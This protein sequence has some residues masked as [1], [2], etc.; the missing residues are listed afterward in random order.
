M[1]IV[2]NKELYENL[3]T[4]SRL[5][6]I[7]DTQELVTGSFYTFYDDILLEIRYDNKIYV[8]E[9]YSTQGE[10]KLTLDILK[11]DLDKDKIEDVFMYDDILII[12]SENGYY[13]CFM[14]KLKENLNDTSKDIRYQFNFYRFNKQIDYRPYSLLNDVICIKEDNHTL[15]FKS[16]RT[17][18]YSKSIVFDQ[19]IEGFSFIS[20]NRIAISFYNEPYL[21]RVYDFENNKYL[22][23]FRLNEN[24]NGYDYDIQ[25]QI[26][27]I[28]KYKNNLF[29][30]T[31]SG[32]IYKSKITDD[33][34]I[35]SLSYRFFNFGSSIDYIKYVDEYIIFMNR[36]NEIM[37]YNYEYDRKEFIKNNYLV[38]SLALSKFMMV[39]SLYDSVDEDYKKR[40]VESGVTPS[41]VKLNPVEKFIMYNPPNIKIIDERIEY[42]Y[43][44]ENDPLVY[45]NLNIKLEENKINNFDQDPYR[46]KFNVADNESNLYVSESDV[47][48]FDKPGSVKN[49]YI[50]LGKKSEFIDNKK[51]IKD[52]ENGNFKYKFTIDNL[53]NYVTFHDEFYPDV[54]KGLYRHLTDTEV[55]KERSPQK[56]YFDGFEDEMKIKDVF[57]NP[58]NEK[59]ISLLSNL[60]NEKVIYPNSKLNINSSD[61]YLDYPDYDSRKY[62]DLSNEYPTGQIEN[63]VVNSDV[64]FDGYKVFKNDLLQ[65]D[66]FDGSINLYLKH[67]A[68]KSY[69]SKAAYNYMIDN[70]QLTKAD[71]III[72][73]KSRSLYE[74]EKL[75]IKHKVSNT[76]ENQTTLLP[77]KGILL[78]NTRVKQFK[79]QNIRI[80][81]KIFKPNSEDNKYY[82]RLNP[83]NYNL[84]IDKEYEM[85]RVSIFGIQIPEGSE[86]M[87]M[88]NGLTN[89]VILYDKLNYI[90]RDIDSLPIVEIAPDGELL[91]ELE[92]R[93][94][95]TEVIVNGLTL[96]PNRDF[97]VINTP[98]DPEI[99]SMVAFRNI[100]PNNAKVEITL[101][102][103]NSSD[104]YYFKYPA[105]GTDNVFVL[106]DDKRIFTN[107][108]YQNDPYK[109]INLLKDSDEE[110][111]TN[112]DLNK[113]YDLLEPLE[114]G[115][116]YTLTMRGSMPIDIDS[117]D[118]YLN[119]ASDKLA[120]IKSSSFDLDTKTYQVTF[121]ADLS[122]SENTK[123]ILKK[124]FSS[125]SNIVI[126]WIKLKKEPSSTRL[127]ENY[128][129]GPE[130]NNKALN[131][132]V[133]VNNKKI[134][135]NYVTVLN[136]KAISISDSYFKLNNVMVRFNFTYDENL[137]RVID[138]YKY[139]NI[140]VNEDRYHD[141]N[142]KPSSSPFD[143]LTSN[144]QAKTAGNLMLLSMLVDTG[145][146]IIDCNANDLPIDINLNTSVIENT[147]IKRNINLD[148]NRT[149][150]IETINKVSDYIN[151]IIDV[152]KNNEN[153][154]LHSNNPNWFIENER[155]IL[156]EP[157]NIELQTNEG[158]SIE[159]LEN[160]EWKVISSNNELSLSYVPE[161]D[162]LVNE[163]DYT[164]SL[165]VNPN[166][167]SISII[168]LE[169]ENDKEI[170]LK[171]EKWT[172]IHLPFNYNGE[173]K[174]DILIKSKE[175]NSNIEL[176]Y[177]DLKLEKGLNEK[178][179]FS[180]APED[181]KPSQFSYSKP[182]EYTKNFSM[183]EHIRNIKFNT[184]KNINLKFELDKDL[185]EFD[186]SYTFSFYAR[187]KSEKETYFKNENLDVEFKLEKDEFRIYL[188]Y[189][190]LTEDSIKYFN[191]FY[192]VQED[193]EKEFEIDLFGFKLEKG[194]RHTDYLPNVKDIQS[195]D[196]ISNTFNIDEKKNSNLLQLEE[197]YKLSLD[198]INEE[199]IRTNLVDKFNL[200][201]DTF[202][203]LSMDI[204]IEKLNDL[205]TNTL[206][207]GLMDY[208]DK[209]LSSKNIFYIPLDNFKKKEKFRAF[210]IFFIS[211]INNFK[212]FVLR[213][214]YS[215]EQSSKNVMEFS[216][217]KLEKGRIATS[218]S[219]NSNLVQDSI[220]MDPE[221]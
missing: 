155:N 149:N 98:N 124:D 90:Q 150:L 126:D 164:F 8:Y 17:D 133:F 139:K 185:I 162:I 109:G 221:I 176:H 79:I 196:T 193:E 206:Y 22:Q 3:R 40:I 203:T 125:S 100:I 35:D 11:E 128:A 175:E 114:K 86:I 76:Y 19:N 153:L 158:N 32:S 215:A 24:L 80:Y 58:D 75:L 54:S 14:D 192:L 184:N 105:V 134:P 116:D 174:I 201:K 77:S 135:N 187:N 183:K 61:M 213:A 12:I 141:E 131:F 140:D 112:E 25:H 146:N 68:L 178:P 18:S 82:H 119:G 99:P 219:V 57:H 41:D 97:F 36:T 102:N 64:Y 127:W 78:P 200:E 172:T 101:L 20:D 111:K 89:N 210:F 142:L 74:T 129:E 21:M 123:L 151:E 154:I 189:I 122:D 106:P 156:K 94:E 30:S 209:Y 51:L 170:D 212:Q 121:K 83:R 87:I 7:Y 173:E 207:A 171:R 6:H 38:K 63:N 198:H 2:I 204:D 165:K 166:V 43:D 104:V 42:R 160:K 47:K 39:L 138:D 69:T 23:K 115:V 202:Y 191:E 220:I 199:Y 157:E 110:V 145:R 163:E 45:I 208:E 52:L 107:N 96:I 136:S 29:Y 117:I 211:D 159:K 16:V 168:G 194:L 1:S 143:T 4:K 152:N 71:K 62:I 103:N 81:V 67:Y 118:V 34:L 91:T 177:K 95:D 31:R 44:E 37:V 55:Y 169:K 27:R 148:M 59:I 197:D 73:N 60:V 33:N 113:E 167:E 5:S 70:S 53:V 10:P 49:M 180:F 195:L 85:L 66:N 46:V 92:R 132:E 181:R 205:K 144:R 120:T 56:N 147:Y 50:K 217:F 188:D 137:Q 218:Y 93:T 72:S 214:G 15:Q 179:S 26:T 9:G 186:R 108:I 84:W 182:D 190:F 48:K 88:D 28:F 130:F 13:R 65:K 161:E 216:R